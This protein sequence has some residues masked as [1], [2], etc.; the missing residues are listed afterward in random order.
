MFPTVSGGQF[1]PYLLPPPSNRVGAAKEETRG[2]LDRNRKIFCCGK[3]WKLMW[4]VAM[5]GEILI[6]TAALYYSGRC[7]KDLVN[8]VCPPNN[9]AT[10][11]QNPRGRHPSDFLCWFLVFAL[12]AKD[13]LSGWQVYLYLI[14]WQVFAHD[15][16]LDNLLL[17]TFVVG[18]LAAL[19]LFLC[20]SLF[21]YSV[22]LQEAWNQKGGEEMEYDFYV[23]GQAVTG[24]V[25]WSF[26]LDL[27]EKPMQLLIDKYTR[28][29]AKEEKEK[30]EKEAEEEEE[31]MEGTYSNEYELAAP[32]S[33]PYAYG[34]Y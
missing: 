24:I 29:D 25:A 18:H 15:K 17:G 6:F 8:G 34:V 9:Q 21:W 2:F 4:V 11:G 1:S 7:R 5:A 13:I 32:Y 28:M 20:T 31:Y 23:Y 10:F 19:G 14:K 16:W 12:C 33:T 3:G 27:D 26:L 30:P 22:V